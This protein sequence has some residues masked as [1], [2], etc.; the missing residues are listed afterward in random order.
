M[1]S[2]ALSN[3]DS[4]DFGRGDLAAA[5][6]GVGRDD[7]GGKPAQRL[8][9]RGETERRSCVR[10]ALP[11]GGDLPH[12]AAADG[13][14]EQLAERAAVDAEDL[15]ALVEVV[16]EQEAGYR[17]DGE[18]RIHLVDA[19]LGGVERPCGRR[20]VDEVELPSGRPREAR[21]ELHRADLALDAILDGCRHVADRDVEQAAESV[22]QPSL[23]QPDVP[24]DERDGRRSRRRRHDLAV[25]VHASLQTI[26]AR[27]SEQLGAKAVQRG[28]DDVDL[29]ECGRERAERGFGRLVRLAGPGDV[30]GILGCEP[31]GDGAPQR[32]RGARGE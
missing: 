29:G 12:D 28:G 24:A 1:V 27:K 10:R 13:L 3:A 30:A 8:L 15:E 23:R 26:E 21:A 4:A 31:V 32:C 20:C 7:P 19:R 9:S 17:V 11:A 16:G 2:I 18:C 22:E 25:S 14:V 5:R 6:G